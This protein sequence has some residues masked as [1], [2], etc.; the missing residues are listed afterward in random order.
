MRCVRKI[1]PAGAMWAEQY[2]DPASAGDA[3]K[4]F[5]HALTLR[6]V[7]LASLN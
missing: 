7:V 6:P 5:L 2:R 1:Q 3:T 4:V